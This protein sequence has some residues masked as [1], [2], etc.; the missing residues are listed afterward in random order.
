M[1]KLV[2]INFNQFINGISTSHENKI[3]LSP[4]YQKYLHDKIHLKLY[5]RVTTA[6]LD[7]E[8]CNN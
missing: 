4:F 2:H 7:E 1:V 6:F 8:I 3:A 5:S